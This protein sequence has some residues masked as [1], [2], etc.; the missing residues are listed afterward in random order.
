MK[1]KEIYDFLTILKLKLIKSTRIIIKPEESLIIIKRKLSRRI[2]AS[3]FSLLFIIG[4]LLI[5]TQTDFFS[6]DDY[7]F[8]V[9]LAFPAGLIFIAYEFYKAN[10]ILMIDIKKNKFDFY[11]L[12]FLPIGDYKFSE[13]KNII[14]E[15]QIVN[16]NYSGVKFKIVFRSDT[17]GE[18]TYESDHFSNQH[19]IELMNQF[20]NFIKLSNVKSNWLSKLPEWDEKQIRLVIQSIKN[21]DPGNKDMHDAFIIYGK[22]IGL[23]D[24]NLNFLR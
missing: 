22:K 20:F 7:N 3:I 19:E 24:E 18:S 21:G 8:L 12:G 16:G 11:F 17:G 5:L 6:S 14:N 4:G 13:F 9:K 10:R 15:T 23:I 2:V 1:E